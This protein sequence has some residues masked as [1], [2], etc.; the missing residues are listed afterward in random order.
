MI[1]NNLR[2]FIGIALAPSITGRLRTVIGPLSARLPFRRWTH[3][4][5]LHVT[6]HFLGDTPEERTA[7]IRS[8][9]RSACAA[10]APIALA[11]AEPGLFGPPSSPRVLWLGLAEPESPGALARL[12]EALAPGLKAAGCD[13]EDRPFRPHVTLARQGG[14]GCGREAVQAAWKACLGSAPADSLT[15]TADRVSLFRTRLGQRPSYERIAEF[16]LGA[17][18]AD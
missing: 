18:I 16:R 7:A 2:L 8:T 15:W 12:H 3:P 4:D 14:A 5:D 17:A 6:L 11:L 13:L 9:V 1:L 10:F